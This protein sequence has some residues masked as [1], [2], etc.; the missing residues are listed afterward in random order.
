MKPTLLFCARR[1]VIRAKRGTGERLRAGVFLIS[2]RFGIDH[3]LG[4][5]RVRRPTVD[6]RSAAPQ[7]DDRASHL[8]DGTINTTIINKINIDLIDQSTERNLPFE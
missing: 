6:G 4:Q 5:N 8:D 1:N 7:H 2:F 3:R